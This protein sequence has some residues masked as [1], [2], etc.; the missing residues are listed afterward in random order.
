MAIILLS[1]EREEMWSTQCLTTL[2]KIN[3]FIVKPLEEK[4]INPLSI[5]KLRRLE[6]ILT[7]LINLTLLS[8]K[9]C[10]KQTSL[11]SSPVFISFQGTPA[12]FV[13]YRVDLDRSPY[14]GSIFDVEEETGIIVTKVNLNEEPSVTF[15]VSTGGD[16][17]GCCIQRSLFTQGGKN[18][19]Q[20]VHADVLIGPTIALQTCKQVHP[21]F[22]KSQNNKCFCSCGYFYR[23]SDYLC[24]LMKTQWIYSD[25]YSNTNRA[26]SAVQWCLLLNA[27]CFSVC[28]H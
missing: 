5:S 27:V 23:A 2:E 10:K 28:P 8:S 11:F 15:K 26:I 4:D 21:S 9:K 16:C 25:A 18:K 12:S 1:N 7:C 6:H 14:S 13:R 20:S 22:K 24:C 17:K 3:L 19:S